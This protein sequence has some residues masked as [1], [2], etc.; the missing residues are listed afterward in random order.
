MVPSSFSKVVQYPNLYHI[1]AVPKKSFSSP[2]W[3]S[4]LLYLHM[5]STNHF[6]K[7]IDK[8]LQLHSA[9]VVVIEFSDQLIY[10][11][12][13]I[14]QPKTSQDMGHLLYMNNY[15]SLSSDLVSPRTEVGYVP[16]VT[17]IPPPS[18]NLNLSLWHSMTTYKLKH[19]FESYWHL[20]TQ[21]RI[22]MLLKHTFH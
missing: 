19:N 15:I 10:L 14:L 11:W 21:A 17:G 5:D 20:Y 13:G 1:I 22:N 4:I 2:I 18:P 16:V 8:F 3:I 9:T 12:W 6:I 7:N